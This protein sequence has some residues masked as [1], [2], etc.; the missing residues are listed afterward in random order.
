MSP[1]ISAGSLDHPSSGPLHQ[2]GR[3]T[4]ANRSANEFTPDSVSIDPLVNAVA[5][6]PIED[7]A[8]NRCLPVAVAIRIQTRTQ[9]SRHKF[10]V[11]LAVSPSASV[12]EE[13]LW[14]VLVHT[15]MSWMTLYYPLLKQMNYDQGLSK[16]PH[17]HGAWLEHIRQAH[18]Q[19][20]VWSRDVVLDPTISKSL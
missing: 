10:W 17:T 1:V 13:G 7:L 2:P 14:R 16:L 15:I 9:P 8:E 4:Q 11:P 20:N 3:R 5:K 6:R 19:A 18:V 12:K